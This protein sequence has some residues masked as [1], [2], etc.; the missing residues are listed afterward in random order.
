M[1]LLYE[2]NCKFCSI[3]ETTIIE[4][5]KKNFYLSPGWCGSVD[6]ASV[7]KPKGCWFGSGQGTCLSCGP[8]ARLGGLQKATEQCF[9]PFLSPSLSLSLKIHE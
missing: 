9:S 7:C 8:G 3:V 2:R 4:I 1:W 5:F 6:R